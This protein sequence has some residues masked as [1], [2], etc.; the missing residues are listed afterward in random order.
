M[1]SQ[2]YTQAGNG[3]PVGVNAQKFYQVF[4]D[5]ALPGNCFQKDGGR[6]GIEF[7]LFS[8]K[9]CFPVGV[10]CYSAREKVEQDKCCHNYRMTV[11]RYVKPGIADVKGIAVGKGV[12]VTTLLEE[13]AW[14]I[15]YRKGTG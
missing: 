4:K 15:R 9:L 6:S 8:L 1:H 7:P 5:Q 3:F 12:L 14:K 11:D 2:R 10:I 13:A